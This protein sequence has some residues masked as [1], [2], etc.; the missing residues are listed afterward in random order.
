MRTAR[1]EDLEDL[2]QL[3]IELF[4]ENC[5][6]EY[7]LG[8]ELDHGK[9]WVEV[10][11]NKV[12]AYLLARIDGDLVDV[13]R[14]GVLPEYRRSGIANRLMKVAMYEA[15]NAMLM[16]RK[17]NPGAIKLYLQLGFEIDGQTED[18]WT[19]LRTCGC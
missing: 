7:S 11:D 10:Q 2:E 12:V 1:K 3:E 9:C 6:N 13:L 18:S 5:F 14:V 19:M 4:P 15:P 16:V 8:I 17:N